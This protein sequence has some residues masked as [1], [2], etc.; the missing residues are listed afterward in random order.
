MPGTPGGDSLRGADEDGGLQV[1]EGVRRTPEGFCLL[2]EDEVSSSGEKQR[3]GQCGHWGAS[4]GGLCSRLHDET[5]QPTCA[6][7]YSKAEAQE[8]GTGDI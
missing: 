1:G 4:P 2:T 8:P 6:V 3:G 5:R 7:F